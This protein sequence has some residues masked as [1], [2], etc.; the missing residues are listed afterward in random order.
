MNEV[1]YLSLADEK[2]GLDI[3][4]PGATILSSFGFNVFA[5]WKDTIGLAVFCAVFLVLGYASMHFLLVE[6]R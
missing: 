5:L 1:R 4:V 2:Y 6:K 3:H